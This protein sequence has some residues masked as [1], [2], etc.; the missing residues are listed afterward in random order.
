MK[1]QTNIF[2][3]DQRVRELIAPTPPWR[4]N[5]H[6]ELRV[7][8]MLF[9]TA[10]TFL[11]LTAPVSVG[12][13][14]HTL[15]PEDTVNEMMNQSAFIA[16]FAIADLLAF[17]QHASQFYVCFACS[18]CFRQA[19]RR[20]FVHVVTRIYRLLSFNKSVAP[21]PLFGEPEPRLRAPPTHYF[22][23]NIQQEQR[24]LLV[25]QAPQIRL[26]FHLQ[27]IAS[28]KQSRISTRRPIAAPRADQ[29]LQ[30]EQRANPMPRCENHV[31]LPAGPGRLMCRYCF[32][33]RLVPHSARAENLF[34]GERK[35]SS[36]LN[37]VSTPSRQQT[38]PTTAE[39]QTEQEEK[40]SKRS[41]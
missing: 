32:A 9:V 29:A 23:R 1:K 20:Q 25:E 33:L 39:V 19:L 27:H 41:S 11:M 34:S 7:S 15:L 13:L 28:N 30:L 5:T 6:A 17:A 31:F 38:Q 22:R 35:S 14:M 26:G 36:S 12:H 10:L 21:L 8:L 2:G 4:R 16:L 18:F 3:L 40:A 24:Q 37:R